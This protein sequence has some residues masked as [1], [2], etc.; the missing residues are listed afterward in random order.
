MARLADH[1]GLGFSECGEEAC[2]RETHLP[3][4]DQEGRKGGQE[5]RCWAGWPRPRQAAGWHRW[6]LAGLGAAQESDQVRVKVGGSLTMV[7]AQPLGWGACVL[8]A[9]A[10]YNPG[11]AAL[12]PG[13]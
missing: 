2:R 7:A 10:S 6:G 4:R 11:R 3:P 12:G 13:R 9:A 1:T 8:L 5:S